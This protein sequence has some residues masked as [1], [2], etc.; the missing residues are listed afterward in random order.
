MNERCLGP[1][2]VHEYS[3]DYISQFWKSYRDFPKFAL[4]MFIEG[5]EG[6][7]ELLS[8]MD[9]DIRNFLENFDG[10]NDTAIFLLADHGLHMGFYWLLTIEGKVEHMTPI[11]FAMVPN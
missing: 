11:S 1:K 9:D 3:F 5:H 10:Y 6:T 4:A 2:Y 8:V 7:S